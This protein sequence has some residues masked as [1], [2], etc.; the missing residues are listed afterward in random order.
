MY[1]YLLLQQLSLILLL[2]T[3][4]FLYGCYIQILNF[5]WF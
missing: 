5:L 3:N 2:K 1:G 4:L